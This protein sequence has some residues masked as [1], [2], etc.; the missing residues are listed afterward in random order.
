ME[1]M[2]HVNWAALVEYEANERAH[3]HQERMYRGI[4]REEHENV[5]GRLRYAVQKRQSKRTS[6]I[7]SVSLRMLRLRS[8]LARLL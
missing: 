8:V 5:Q 3:A 2:N 1:H 4:W 6:S 7:G